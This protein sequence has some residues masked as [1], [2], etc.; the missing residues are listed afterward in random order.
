MSES[1]KLMFK[2][3]QAKMNRTRNELIQRFDYYKYLV[4]Q[5]IDFYT[6]KENHEILKRNLKDY[7]QYLIEKQKYNFSHNKESIIDKYKYEKYKLLRSLGQSKEK[8]SRK[9]YILKDSA[10]RA[11]GRISN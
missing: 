8:L 2:K 1:F 4:S 6:R 7:S 10:E 5:Y 3:L 11:L 9:A